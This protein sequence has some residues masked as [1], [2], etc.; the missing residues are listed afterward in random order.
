MER[1]RINI[2]GLRAYVGDDIDRA[3][4][5]VGVFVRAALEQGWTEGDIDRV[6]KQVTARSAYERLMPYIEPGASDEQSYHGAHRE[7]D[8]AEGCRRLS[9]DPNVKYKPFRWSLRP[10]FDAIDQGQT[11]GWFSRPRLRVEPQERR[12]ER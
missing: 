5:F 8:Y 1:V 12:Q 3:C 7:D 6:V 2:E 11:E 9:D 10:L 4:H